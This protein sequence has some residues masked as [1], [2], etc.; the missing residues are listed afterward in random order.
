MTDESFTPPLPA[1][2][3]PEDFAAALR[4]ITAIVGEK[5]VYRDE[6]YDLDGYRDTYAVVD[7]DYHMPSAAVAPGWG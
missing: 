4:E 3:S 7:P 1:G 2:V 5:W 6:K